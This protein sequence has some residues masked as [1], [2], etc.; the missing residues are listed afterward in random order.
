VQIDTSSG[1]HSQPTNTAAAETTNIAA[2]TTTTATITAQPNISRRTQPVQDRASRQDTATTNTAAAINGEPSFL[3]ERVSALRA[4]LDTLLAGLLFYLAFYL[5]PFNLQTR[6]R[7]WGRYR[8][9]ILWCLFPGF[10]VLIHSVRLI[11]WLSKE[12]HRVVFASGRRGRGSAAGRRHRQRRSHHRQR[13]ERREGENELNFE[14]ASVSIDD[15]LALGEQ[16]RLH[17]MSDEQTTDEDTLP[18]EEEFDDD[19]S[20]SDSHEILSL[21]LSDLVNESHTM[22]YWMQR[23]SICF[24]RR[25]DL[26]LRPCRDQ[27]CSD[28]FQRYVREVVNNSWGLS[29]TQIKCPVCMDVL[30]QHEW[31][32]ASTGIILNIRFHY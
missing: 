16:T 27:F 15:F 14:A 24:D 5:L 32:Q 2:A 4:T 28:C 18:E 3:A 7:R 26:C 10:L 11:V 21:Q 30:E 31:K 19:D 23:C 6:L 29:I 9:L 1:R 25:M 17:N 12:G 22:E 8:H 13:M 20:S